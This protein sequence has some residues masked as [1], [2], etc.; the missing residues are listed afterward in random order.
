M[1]RLLEGGSLITAISKMERSPRVLF[2]LQAYALLN[3]AQKRALLNGQPVPVSAMPRQAA[4]RVQIAAALP[5]TSAQ[6]PTL[7]P[8]ESAQMA[9]VMQDPAG[10]VGAHRLVKGAGRDAGG[11]RV[12]PLA[13]EPLP[14]ERAKVVKKSPTLHVTLG[15]TDGERV[16]ELAFITTLQ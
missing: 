2:A 15:L 3:A 4:A 5:D 7:S 9:L 14:E 13:G 8:A 12:S 10:R 11:W 6:A 16:V 1:A